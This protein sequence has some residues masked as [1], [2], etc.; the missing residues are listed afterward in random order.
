MEMNIRWYEPNRILYWDCSNLSTQADLFYAN[1][2]LCEYLDAGL[3]HRVNILMD[4]QRVSRSDNHLSVNGL[5]ANFS[6]QYHPNTRMIIAFHAQNSYMTAP[7]MVFAKRS[8]LRFR[9]A[10]DL[11]SALELCARP[12]GMSRV[13]YGK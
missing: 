11:R 1:K 13:M 4:W 12:A 3:R 6:F 8:H 2:V 10:R 9:V 5:R 7:M